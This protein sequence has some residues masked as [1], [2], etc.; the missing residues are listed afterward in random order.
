MING[1]SKL[2]LGYKNNPI[3]NECPFAF[4]DINGEVL[5]Y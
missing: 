1:Y 5:V 2:S 3:F 4:R